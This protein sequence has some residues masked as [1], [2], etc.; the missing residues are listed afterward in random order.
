MNQR[1]GTDIDYSTEKT[2]MNETRNNIDN[3][4][5]YNEI[6]TNYTPTPETTTTNEG[7]PNRAE[8]II[9]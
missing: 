1:V 3:Y 8:E 4:D 2:E 7:T 9:T 5:V 6:R